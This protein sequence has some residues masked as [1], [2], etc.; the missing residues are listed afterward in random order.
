VSGGVVFNKRCRETLFDLPTV[1][2]LGLLEKDAPQSIVRADPRE[3]HPL[4]TAGLQVSPQLQPIAEGRVA[5]ENL[6]AAGMVVGGFA[7]RY[8]LCADG[9]ALASGVLAA[10]HGLAA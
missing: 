5:Y 8:A 9:V 10:R 2:E 4:M 3:S 1:S 6:F 7:S